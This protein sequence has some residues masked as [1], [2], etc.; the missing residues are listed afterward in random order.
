MCR[1]NVFLGNDVLCS[2]LAENNILR[3]D[4][5]L[6]PLRSLLHHGSFVTIQGSFEFSLAEQPPRRKNHGSDDQERRIPALYVQ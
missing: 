2:F 4:F 5:D 6:L 1:S 3:R